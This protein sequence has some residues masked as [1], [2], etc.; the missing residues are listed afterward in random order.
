MELDLSAFNEVYKILVEDLIQRIKQEF[1]NQSIQLIDKKYEINDD[2]ILNIN[3]TYM[4]ID[5]IKYLDNES[6]VIAKI[7]QLL[8]N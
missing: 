2:I 8:H 7:Q 1:P 6:L 4:N 5:V 3:D